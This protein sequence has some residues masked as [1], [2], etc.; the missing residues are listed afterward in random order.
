[1][2]RALSAVLGLV[3]LA[4]VAAPVAATEPDGATTNA[5]VPAA[6]AGAVI[7]G[8]VIVRWRADADAAAV[9]RTRGL[10]V[11]S[12]LAARGEVKPDVLAEAIEKYELLDPAAAPSEEVNPAEQQG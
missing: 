3:L 11:L 8:R 2:S 4:A 6:T 1:M 5:S 7:P 12:E 9:V 10:A